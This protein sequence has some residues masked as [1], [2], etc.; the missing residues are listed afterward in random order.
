MSPKTEK[1]E[2][3]L[4]S[5]GRAELMLVLLAYILV[6]AF[7]VFT[8]WSSGEMHEHGISFDYYNLQVDGFRQGHLYLPVQPDPRLMALPDPY[9][10]AQNSQLR[11][12]DASYYKG[13]YYIYFGPV[14]GV[15]LMW[16]YA[17]LTGHHLP[18]AV[19]IMIFCLTGIAAVS[20]LVLGF[21]RRYFPEAPRWLAP[22]GVL[23]LGFG[24]HVLAVARR[25]QIW[26]LPI[27]AGYAFVSLALLASFWAVHGRR[28][29]LALGLAGLFLALAIGSRPTTLLS[30]G[31]IVL[32]LVYWWWRRAEA[33]GLWWRAGIA[34]AVPLFVMFAGLAWYN[35]ARFDSPFQFGQAYQLT[36]LKEGSVPHFNL[37]FIP[38]NLHVYYSLPVQWTAEWPFIK[39]PPLPSWPDGYFS[40]EELYC[41][42][43][44]FPF[45]WFAPLGLMNLYRGACQRGGGLAVAVLTV[46][47]VYLPLG[48]LMLA[49]FYAAERY[50]V[51][52]VPALALLAVLGAVVCVG[53][54][55]SRIGQI[56]T[57]GAIVVSAVVTIG[58]G[59]LISFDYHGR[60]MKNTSP[61]TWQKISTT[62][63]KI[64]HLGKP[65]PR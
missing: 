36:S 9:D 3:G 48:L 41:L 39:S 55:R 31:L 10:P 30:S 65:E 56:V 25:P 5:A 49:F 4:R 52:F 13:H 18:P 20:A 32:P 45:L 14:P 23:V 44:I 16:P 46:L 47:S 63:E 12:G 42:A 43:L 24:S 1:R 15:V 59:L 19:V 62:A 54:I 34:A 22:V 64:I 7:Y 17:V 29:V 33:P 2:P 11:L 21:K 50:M 26:E 8:I 37:R 51:D 58:F 35:H 6:A 53:V 60:S 40:G 61:Q 38:Y 27:S 57:R 28:R